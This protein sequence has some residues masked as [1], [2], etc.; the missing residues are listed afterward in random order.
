MLEIDRKKKGPE[1]VP[2]SL[3]NRLKPLI[4]LLETRGTQNNAPVP[5][6]YQG[7]GAIIVKQ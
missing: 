2:I 3:N 6:D 7:I 4:N 5:P 1:P